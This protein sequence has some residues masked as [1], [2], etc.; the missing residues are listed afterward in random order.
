[1]NVFEIF[2]QALKTTYRKDFLKSVWFLALPGF[3]IGVGAAIAIIPAL[4][5]SEAHNGAFAMSL[6]SLIT[7]WVFAIIGIIILCKGFWDGLLAY[8]VIAFMT[9][10]A[11]DEEKILPK[12]EYLTLLKGRQ[13]RYVGLLLATAGII[14]LPLAVAFSS[15]IFYKIAGLP[16]FS[17][18]CLI[19]GLI[20]LFFIS[21]KLSL[22]YQVFA[23][24]PAYSIKE[25]IIKAYNLTSK[26]FWQTFGLMLLIQIP[27]NLLLLAAWNLTGKMSNWLLTSFSI[28]YAPVYIVALTLWYFEIKRRKNI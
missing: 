7:I 5:I 28:F 6:S 9:K 25:I 23:F 27:P 24:K 11:R 1:M 4:K 14:C 8:L 18:I 16:V 15:L 21:I 20:S 10:N 13:G 22:A 12:K 3:L 2:I 26:Y 19:I 17:F